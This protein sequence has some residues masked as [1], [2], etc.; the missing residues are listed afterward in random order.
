MNHIDLEVACFMR[1]AITFLLLIFM[2]ITSSCAES[3]SLR[4]S[5]N[6]KNSEN[7]L[8][9]MY[10]LTHSE[11]YITKLSCECGNCPGFEGIYTYDQGPEY[12]WKLPGALE[13]K[14][15]LRIILFDVINGSTAN[16]TLGLKNV[17][18]FDLRSV[19]LVA[20][21][22]LGM[23]I[24]SST[25]PFNQSSNKVAWSVFTLKPGESRD[26]WF[27]ADVA[28][29]QSITNLSAEASG[30]GEDDLIYKSKWDAG[31]YEVKGD[32]VWQFIEGVRIPNDET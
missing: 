31:V 26:I 20:T 22:P 29:G 23:T 19:S 21:L 27:S 28:S 9:K 18:T 32:A 17:G 4:T 11:A 6:A 14:S 16:Y 25:Q 10:Q 12:E 8:C 7:C 2:L 30:V 15:P 3:N 1:L 24:N 13:A 5:S